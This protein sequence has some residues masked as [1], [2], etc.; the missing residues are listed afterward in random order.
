[1]QDSTR[2]AIFVSL[3]VVFLL[4]VGVWWYSGFSLEFMKFFAAEPGTDAL[5]TCQPRPACLDAVPSC[6]IAEPA[7]GWCPAP[8]PPAPSGCYYEV[9]QC[10]TTP[11]DPQLVCPS[12]KPGAGM[13]QCSPATQTVRVGQ[14]ARVSA[15]NGD[16]VYVWFAPGTGVDSGQGQSGTRG[17]A[18]IPVAY[19][20]PGTKKVT[21][22]AGRGDSA[23]SVDSV[24]CTVV[25]TP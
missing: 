17:E 9:I 23:G 6:D 21:V 24:A 14:T 19:S 18:T 4:L 16:G 10:F 2:K 12:L 11:C 25:V 13:V 20:S 15:T 5:P 1:M 22:Q 7:D 8:L 3:G